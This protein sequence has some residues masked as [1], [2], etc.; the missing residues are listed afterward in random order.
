MNDI[1]ED[2]LV[3]VIL[4]EVQELVSPGDEHNAIKKQSLLYNF[5]LLL[6]KF[7]DNLAAYNDLRCAHEQLL[8]KHR[9]TQN[10]L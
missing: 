3:K 1:A 2:E 7:S 9:E 4:E 10:T 8:T 6:R 5:E